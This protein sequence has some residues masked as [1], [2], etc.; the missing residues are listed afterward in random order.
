MAIKGKGKTKARRTVTRGPRPGYVEPPKPLIKR[1][2]FKWT[3]FAFLAVSVVVIILSILFITQS[4]NR[5][6]QAAE[7]A[8]NKQ[9]R[10]N[11]YALPVIQYLQ[12]VAEPLPGGPLVGTF[13]N[14]PTQFADLQSGALSPEDAKAAAALVIRDAKAAGD[15]IQAVNVPTVVNTKNFPELLDL[16]DSQTSLVSSMRLY[17][18]I[19][20]GLRQA[21]D[22]TGDEQKALIAE[23]QAIIT[24]AANL[25]TDGYQKLVNAQT[26]VGLPPNVFPPKEPSPAPTASPTPSPEPS[27]SGSASPEPSGSASPE[28][29]KSSKPKPS[30]S[31]GGGGGGGGGNG[32]GGGGNGGGRNTPK[33]TASA[34]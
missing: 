28:P 15:S 11:R 12:P 30:G 18:Q 23:N 4:N 9:T 2:W 33:P 14:L 22:M 20:K 32:N 10:V 21:A 16:I 31:A 1:T 27:A 25:F 17:E 26:S 29:S 13:P 6:E 24:V 5:K 19:G 3:A 8:H 34:G 7:R